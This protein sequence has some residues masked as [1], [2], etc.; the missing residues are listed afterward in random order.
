[1]ESVS[2]DN[3]SVSCPLCSDTRVNQFFIDQRRNYMHCKGCGLVFVPKVFHL[4]KADEKREYDLHQN[5]VQDEGYR[6][7]LGRVS[8]PLLLRLP[9]GSRGL[10]FGCGPGPALAHILEE[11]GHHMD[12]YDPY[13]APNE[14]FKT[15]K[16]DF[17]TA[18]EVVEHLAEPGSELDHLWSLM[19]RGGWLAIMTKRVTSLEAFANWH[20]KNDPTHISFFCEFTFNFLAKNWETEAEFIGNDV[21]LFQKP[22]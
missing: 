6:K 8:K 19:N 22:R 3:S 9:N 14:F 1:M 15:K 11:A 20:Y 10:D 2:G 17:I 4:N 5:C 21:V 16:Y 18:T 7:F 12:I 13:Y